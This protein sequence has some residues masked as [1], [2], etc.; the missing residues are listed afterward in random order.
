MIKTL[1]NVPVKVLRDTLCN[2][3]G[4]VSRKS[5]TMMFS[6]NFCLITAL[7]NFFFPQFQINMIIWGSFAG[8]A[9]LNNTLIHLDKKKKET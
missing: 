3:K 2:P 9:G 4:K 5:I 6:F 8:A 7:V 1:L